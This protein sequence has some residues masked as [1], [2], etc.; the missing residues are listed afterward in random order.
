M[1]PVF[2]AHGIYHVFGEPY[3]L[4]MMMAAMPG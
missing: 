4:M 2:I 1:T 3:L